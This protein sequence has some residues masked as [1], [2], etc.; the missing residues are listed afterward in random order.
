VFPGRVRPHRQ[1]PS[2]DP[3]A[4][5]CLTPPVP[6]LGRHLPPWT[7]HIH[8]QHLPPCHPPQLPAVRGSGRAALFL[9]F[10]TVWQDERQA[11]FA[12]DFSFFL[13]QLVGSGHGRRRSI[14]RLVALSIF[15]FPSLSRASHP[16]PPP[17]SFIGA[18]STEQEPKRLHTQRGSR[19]SFRQSSGAVRARIQP[20]QCSSHV[21]ARPPR[22]N[23]GQVFSRSIRSPS[24]AE[25]EQ[26]AQ[27]E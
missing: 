3:L 8:F 24:Y 12:V 2:L 14:Q 5:R 7:S 23:S 6:H 17:I 11:L 21:P 9:N 25:A 26:R 10:L 16:S 18:G 19:I 20:N 1:Q 27:N 22:V 15:L 4:C 13:S